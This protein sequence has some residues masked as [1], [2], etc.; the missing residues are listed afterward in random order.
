MKKKE[1]N[2]RNTCIS[3]VGILLLSITFVGIF[4][5]LK[6]VD[7]KIPFYYGGGD[8]LLTFNNAKT[9]QDTGWIF[10]SNNLGAPFS[11]NYFDF[12]TTL[13]CNFDNLITKLLVFITGNIFEAVDIQYLLL[14]PT[15]AL[16]SY[17]VM[18]QLKVRNLFAV[19]CSLTYAFLPFIFLRYRHMSLCYYQF[20]PPAMLLCVWIF[21]DDQFFVIGKG[22]FKYKKNILALVFLILISNNGMFYYPFFT[23]FFLLVAGISAAIKNRSF[24]PVLRGV[25]TV[26][27]IVTCVIVN[28]IPYFIYIANNGANKSVA[29]RARF[30]AEL[31]GLKIAQLFLPINTHGINI[32]GKVVTYYNQ[33]DPLVNENFTAYLGIAGISGFL[34]L[35][36]TLFVKKIND[37]DPLVILSELNICAILLATI[38]GFSSLIALTVFPYIRAYNRISVFIAFISL[39]GLSLLLNSISERLKKPFSKYAFMTIASIVLIV[40][41]VEQF[42]GNVPDYANTKTLFLSD[43]KFIVNIESSVPKGS[44]IYEM[45]YHK[46]PEEGPVNAMSDYQLIDPA[47][48]SKDLKWSYGGMKGRK[49]DIW[50][51]KVASL[52]IEKRIKT[53]SLANFQGIYIDSRAYKADEI[54]QLTKELKDILKVD[55]EY[56]ENNLLIFYN[57]SEYNK[58]Q[59]ATYSGIQWRSL[60]QQVLND[61]LILQ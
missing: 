45:P 52:P 12:Q 26:L 44:M 57:M 39:M 31:Y 60:N 30:E 3:I 58:I 9:I 18:K 35:L 22:F 19:L 1:S 25:S 42:P 13:L 15:I 23:C 5:K 48:L 14:F 21:T 32:L 50:N 2:L 4:L 61:P 51:E 27:T 6:N 47:L 41:I 28:M 36:I 7:L 11:T 16:I 20:I 8:E 56:S 24:K 49:S 34:I 29:Q 53:I 54:K 37:K 55:P 43:Q 59:K 10:F 46:Y 40:C 33:H 38:G 17:Y